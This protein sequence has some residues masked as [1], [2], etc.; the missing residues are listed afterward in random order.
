[1]KKN[2][3]SITIDTG[4]AAFDNDSDGN[5]ESE[6]ASILKTAS[7]KLQDGHRDFKLYDSNGNA[8][9]RVLAK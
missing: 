4:N 1:M 3:I 5:W 7:E 8:V 9:G 6:V 2:T